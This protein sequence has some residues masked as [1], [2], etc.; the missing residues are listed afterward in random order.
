MASKELK[1]SN[2][3]SDKELSEGESCECDEHKNPESKKEPYRPE[4]TKILGDK[5]N[6]D[7]TIP[8]KK[9]LR[10]EMKEAA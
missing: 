10:G 7:G 6:L 3:L 1:P 2:D 8:L 9:E 4:W 5:A